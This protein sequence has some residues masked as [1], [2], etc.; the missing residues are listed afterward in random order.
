M[1]EL[2]E[3]VMKF[4][5]AIRNGNNKLAHAQMLLVETIITKYEKEKIRHIVLRD[6]E[7]EEEDYTDWFNLKTIG[8][9]W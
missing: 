1:E 8:E 4:I 2:I 9:E 3:E 5:A 6:D 7:N